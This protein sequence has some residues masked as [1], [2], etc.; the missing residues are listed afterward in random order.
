MRIL[1][2]A[3]FV[4]MVA[5][6]GEPVAAAGQAAAASNAPPLAETTVTAPRDESE[7]APVGDYAQPKWTDRR[8]FPGVRLYVA[9]PGAATFEFWGE[10]KV[11]SDAEP[12]RLRTMYEVSF[13]LGHRLQLDLYLRTE[14]NGADVLRIESE[15]LELRWALADWGVLWGN[16]TLYLEYIRQT[17]GP[18]KAEVKVLLGGALSPRWFWGANLFFETELWGDQGHE[19]GAV[20]GV[21]YSLVDSKLS[22]GAETRVEVVDTR[23]T[24]LTPLEIEWLIGPSLS[25]RPVP[26]AHVLFTAYLG[27]GFSR[28]AGSDPFSARLVFQPSLVIGWRL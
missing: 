22:L 11:T 28:G 9:P 21:A 3:L 1:V 13:G 25:W 2:S 5:F 20:A 14:S 15:R 23:A 27:P 10:G 19:Y 4:S 6:A 24:R 7:N 18:H 12:A 8:R 16:P 17:E 26:Q